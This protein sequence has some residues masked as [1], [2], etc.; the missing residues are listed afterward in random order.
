MQHRE[1]LF[2]HII[3]IGPPHR[4]AVPCKLISSSFPAHSQSSVRSYSCLFRNEVILYEVNARQG[5]FGGSCNH[6]GATPLLVQE[7][8]YRFESHRIEALNG[9]NLREG[10]C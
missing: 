8:E 7:N 4:A 9:N 6:L 3:V 10:S 2:D 1:W 5:I